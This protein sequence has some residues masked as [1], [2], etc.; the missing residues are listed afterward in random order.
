MRVSRSSLIVTWFM[1]IKAVLSCGVTP[2]S[3]SLR[4]DKGPTDLVVRLGIAAAKILVSQIQIATFLDTA[5][6]YAD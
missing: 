4:L 2:F 3:G 1:T 5:S 6:L